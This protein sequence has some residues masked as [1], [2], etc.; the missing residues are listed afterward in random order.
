[1]GSTAIV[2]DI[3]PSLGVVSAENWEL[4]SERGKAALSRLILYDVANG[5]AQKHV[6]GDW[7]ERGVEDEE[8]RGIAEQVR[9]WSYFCFCFV[10]CCWLLILHVVIL[11]NV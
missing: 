2:P 6:Y 7:P 11:V 5:H 10:R 3:G 9:C 1:M 4:L 8:K